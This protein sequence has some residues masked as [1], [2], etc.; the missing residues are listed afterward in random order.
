MKKPRKNSQKLLDKIEP[1]IL[2]AINPEYYDEEAESVKDKLLFVHRTFH[3]E[4]VYPENLQRYK[5]YVELM[6]QWLIGLPGSVNIEFRNHRIL[7]LG[8][9]WGFLPEEPTEDQEYD[10][11]DRWFRTMADHIIGMM[12]RNGILIDKTPA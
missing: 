4:Y 3:T 12:Y 6:A 10:F 11:L 5:T 2:D 9:E 7:E 1:Y 8:H